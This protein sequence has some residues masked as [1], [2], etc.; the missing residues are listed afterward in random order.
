METK[1][2]FRKTRKLP[3]EF[4]VSVRGRREQC[5][6][7]SRK[8]NELN[9]TG[10]RSEQTSAAADRNSRVWGTPSSASSSSRC[11][12]LRCRRPR[13]GNDS[14]ADVE[15]TSYALAAWRRNYSSRKVASNKSPVKWQHRRQL[16]QGEY[17]WEEEGEGREERDKE[18]TREETSLK[19]IGERGDTVI[20]AGREGES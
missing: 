12:L 5:R 13:V 9:V 16:A 2:W 18:N 8:R 14:V 7:Y 17:V 6:F 10:L 15:T 20:M 3:T 11:R 1:L 4:I 19:E